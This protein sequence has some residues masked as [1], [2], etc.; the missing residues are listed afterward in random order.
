MYKHV[1]INLNGCTCNNDK[2]E[3]NKIIALERLH[4]VYNHTG[5][6]EKT[7]KRR[8]NIKYEIVTFRKRFL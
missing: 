5:G 8:F 7:C 3:I 1:K 4:V 2:E 6:M